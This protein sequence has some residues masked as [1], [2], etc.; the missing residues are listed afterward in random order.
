M[1]LGWRGWRGGGRGGRGELD[2]DGEGRGELDVGWGFSG[3]E[4]VLGSI[5]YKGMRDMAWT[6]CLGKLGCRGIG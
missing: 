3:G 5:S 6:N 2:G 4:V 1:Q